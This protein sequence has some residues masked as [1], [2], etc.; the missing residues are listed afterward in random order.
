M[1][2]KHEEIVKKVLKS[3]SNKAF[4]ACINLQR[5]DT[6]PKFIEMLEN[7][8]YFRNFFFEAFLAGIYLEQNKPTFK[9]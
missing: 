8:D 3:E 5:E 6:D 4:D 2:M 1:E 7:S 9:V